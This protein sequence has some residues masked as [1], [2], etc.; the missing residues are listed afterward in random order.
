MALDVTPMR[1]GSS[2]WK[3]NTALLRD[4]SCRGSCVS[5]GRIG[6]NKSNIIPPWCCGGKGSQ[7][8]TSRGSSSEKGLRD[9]MR[10]R[11][12]KTY[13]ACLY[14]ALKHP[15]Q[16]A[17]RR[18]AINSPKAMVVHLHTA[19]LTQGRLSYKLRTYSSR[20]GCPSFN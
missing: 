10:R 9:D 14:D 7:K 12:W 17:E 5:I 6:P 18:A 20:N 8:Y 16:N 19:R 1:R 2:Y 15:L 4:K 3:I 11:R 13:Y